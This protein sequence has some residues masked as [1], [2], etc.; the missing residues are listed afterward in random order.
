MSKSLPGDFGPGMSNAMMQLDESVHDHGGRLYT[1]TSTGHMLYVVFMFPKGL[2]PSVAKPSLKFLASPAKLGY[3]LSK[4]F[5]A[6]PSTGW[7]ISFS[8]ETRLSLCHRVDG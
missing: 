3:T 6:S 1:L 4:C 7:L 5:Q 2:K 8:T